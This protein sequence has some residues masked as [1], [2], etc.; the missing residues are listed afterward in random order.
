MSCGPPGSVA[1]SDVK[2]EDLEGWWLSIEPELARV[3]GFVKPPDGPFSVPID[4]AHRE[5][6]VSANYDGPAS[7]ASMSPK[8]WSTY[9][10]KEGKI[11][12]T[13]LD[14]VDFDPGTTFTT[15]ISSL[16]KRD[17]LVIDASTGKR[18]YRWNEHCPVR[19][20]AGWGRS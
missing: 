10:V 13:V 16:V 4:F 20:A 1:P 5:A 6:F 3:F 2:P 17:T 7:L 19:N 18:S 12:E 14:S 11:V 9:E 15:P 8:A